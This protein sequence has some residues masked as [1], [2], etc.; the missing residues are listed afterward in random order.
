[1]AYTDYTSNH[2]A[3]IDLLSTNK[4]TNKQLCKLTDLL[5]QVVNMINTPKKE[6]DYEVVCI[7]NDG[8]KTKVIGFLVFDQ[9]T[10]TNP[11][12]YLDGIDVTGSY[13]QVSCD[14]V[15]YDY[16]E[17]KVCVDGKLWTSIKVYDT[18]AS[19]PSLITTLWLDENNQSITAPSSNLINNLNCQD[20]C[21][22]VISYAFADDLSTLIP[23]NTFTIENRNCC[24]IKVI[25]SVGE[26][27][28][29]GNNAKTT[30]Q[31]NCVFEITGVELLYGKDCDLNK[32][33]ITGYK[34]K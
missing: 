7:S 20:K 28:V 18:T 33:L 13:T 9:E 17:S 32:V 4:A 11:L 14:G 21:Q 25:T 22:P 29:F 12:I 8:G 26:F 24:N 27:I 5:L 30:E 1:M 2:N 34:V 10:I 6:Y 15:K 3:L 31:L 19:L 16:E 23:S